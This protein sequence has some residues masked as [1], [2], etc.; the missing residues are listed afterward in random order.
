M[1]AKRKTKDEKQQPW[2]GPWLIHF[3]QR[4]HDDDPGESV[5]ARNFLDI[6]PLKV[7]A[8]MLAVV[9]AVSE[10]PPPSFSGGG[11]WE[12]MHGNRTGRSQH[13]SHRRKE[14]AFPH[15]VVSS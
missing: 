15:Q 12:A 6:C 2:T 7:A 1:T 3:F 8:T 4:H 13:R 14:Q 10:A 9:K 5:P 11:K